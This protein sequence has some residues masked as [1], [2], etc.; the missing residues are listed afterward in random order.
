VSHAVGHIDAFGVGLDGSLWH[1]AGQPSQD[2]TGPVDQTTWASLQGL[3]GGLLGVPSVASWGAQRLDVFVR[4]TDNS[5][6]QM[7]WDGTWHPWY[8]L[9]GI[10]TSEPVVVAAQSNQ[11]D[12]FVLGTQGSFCWLAWRNAWQPWS[13]PSNG[14]AFESIPTPVVLSANRTDVVVVARDDHAYHKSLIGTTWSVAWDD[15]GG[16][17]NG[18]PQVASFAANDASVVGL[19]LDGQ[20][21]VANW[22][23]T[24]PAWT[25]NTSWI[26][27][28]G[29]FQTVA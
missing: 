22:S 6:Y 23:T 9:G 17:L 10:L 20:M 3:G 8:G 24:V 16:P 11:L 27:L 1:A 18:A 29:K 28:G 12:I 13:C 15:L 2:G 5:L 4:G 21:Y 25:G 19:G 26:S 7:W 14:T